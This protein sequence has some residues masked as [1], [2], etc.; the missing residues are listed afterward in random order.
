MHNYSYK[1]PLF[2][3]DNTKHNAVFE[4]IQYIPKP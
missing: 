2:K 1:Q 4:N 3:L